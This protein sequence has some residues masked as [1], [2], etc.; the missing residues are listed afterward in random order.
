MPTGP[1]LVP[2]VTASAM[3]IKINGKMESFD[4]PT[5]RLTD[6][7]ASK[8]VRPETVAVEI[9]LNI[10]EKSRYADTL[11]KAGD[12]VEIVRFVGGGA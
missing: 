5:V 6:Y 12:E 2:A 1:A 9:N 7:L 10:I 8:G 4:A 11:L 3:Q